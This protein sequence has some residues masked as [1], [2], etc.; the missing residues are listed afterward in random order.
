MT[1]WDIGVLARA[2]HAEIRGGALPVSVEAV[3]TDS[4][5]LPPNAL[6]VAL[7]GPRYDGHAFAAQA[8]AAGARAVMVDPS[9]DAAVAR[10]AVPRLVVSDTLRALADLARL[11]RR[12]RGKPVVAVTGSNGKTTT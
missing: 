5:S 10:L 7:R 11:V 8:V 9:G 6:F 3:G 2:A 12:S 1:A 4:R